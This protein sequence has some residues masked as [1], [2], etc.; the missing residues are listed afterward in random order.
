MSSAVDLI[1]AVVEGTTIDDVFEVMVGT[2]VRPRKRRFSKRGKAFDPRT[3]KRK[4]PKK[5]RIARRSAVRHRAKR[6]M[7][8]R[9]FARSAKGRRFHKKLGKL[10]ARIRR[11]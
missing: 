8:A 3:G 7:A 11:R 6:K 9:K 4:D 2:A 5:R 1:D 10:V